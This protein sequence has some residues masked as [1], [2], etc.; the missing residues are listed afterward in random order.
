MT[1]CRNFAISFVI[2]ISIIMSVEMLI[3]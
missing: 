1:I 2:W 3:L